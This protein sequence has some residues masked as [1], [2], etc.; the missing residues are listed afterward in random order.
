ML[1]YDILLF[2][3]SE[4]TGPVTGWFG[5]VVLSSS[6]CSKIQPSWTL[7]TFDSNVMCPPEYGSAR[8]VGD[9]KCVLERFHGIKFISVKQS[10]ECRSFFCQALIEGPT[11]L[12]RIGTNSW[13]T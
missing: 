10:K 8:T 13:K 6:F 5:V 3:V 4:G 7:P 9:T 1:G 11:I 2:S 12:V